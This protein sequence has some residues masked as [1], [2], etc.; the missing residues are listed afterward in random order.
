MLTLLAN[1]KDE[2]LLVLVI[3]SA[4]VG[5]GLK[6]Y[7]FILFFGDFNGMLG[8]IGDG[9][10]NL[11]GWLGLFLDYGCFWQS[12]W[13]RHSLRCSFNLNHGRGQNLF[14]LL[15]NGIDRLQYINDFILQLR[16]RMIQPRVVH[17]VIRFRA[18]LQYVQA[19]NDMVQGMLLHLQLLGETSDYGL[20]RAI[21]TLWGSLLR[22]ADQ[23][24]F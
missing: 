12:L 22:Q 23:P 3:V 8:T 1:A 17:K 2:A 9:N 21:L 16:T 20:Q 6:F 5:N 13:L 11:N 15:S 4:F 14:L 18:I 19:I 10:D 24:M 7:A